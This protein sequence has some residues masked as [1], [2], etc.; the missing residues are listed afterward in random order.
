MVQAD[1]LLFKALANQRRVARVNADRCPGADAIEEPVPVKHHLHPEFG[2][3]PTIE[4]ASNFK[5]AHRED[6][7]RHSIDFDPHQISPPVTPFYKRDQ[8]PR[9]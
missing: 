6:H 4:F 7:V 9:L 8:M 1:S 2:Q 5:A 3:E